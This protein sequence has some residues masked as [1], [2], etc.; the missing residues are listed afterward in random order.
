MQ[1]SS[2]AGLYQISHEQTHSGHPH[3]CMEPFWF[4][5]TIAFTN[6]LTGNEN[7]NTLPLSLIEQLNR[8]L[9]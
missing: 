4:G 2:H 9:P 8:F 1:I 6:Y 7:M 5:I 3:M